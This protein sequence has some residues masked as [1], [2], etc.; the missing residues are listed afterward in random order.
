METVELDFMKAMK[1]YTQND[2]EDGADQCH[3]FGILMNCVANELRK[4]NTTEQ[5]IAR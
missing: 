1:T 5:I 4:L 3:L 2:R